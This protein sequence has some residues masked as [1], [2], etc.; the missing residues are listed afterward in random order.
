MLNVLSLGMINVD[1][2]VLNPSDVRKIRSI[3]DR[4]SI[5]VCVFIP[6][7]ASRFP[8]LLK[9]DTEMLASYHVASTLL[10]TLLCLASYEQCSTR[11]Y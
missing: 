6:G 9:R 7:I 1:G 11:L 4:Y 8:Q 3:A 5:I 10:A 2:I